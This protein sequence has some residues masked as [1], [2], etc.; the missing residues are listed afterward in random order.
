M[1]SGSR[2]CKFTIDHSSLTFFF[3]TTGSDGYR[4]SLTPGGLIYLPARG[5]NKAVRFE[6]N[7]YL[8]IM[9][10]ADTFP[11]FRALF[12]GQIHSMLPKG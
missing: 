3:R 8:S 9:P 12:N 6:T 1:V 10:S 2:K 5:S 11:N 7:H 4:D